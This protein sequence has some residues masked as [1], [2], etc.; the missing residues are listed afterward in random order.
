[1]LLSLNAGGQDLVFSQFYNSPLHLNPAL[2]GTNDFAQFN[3]NYRLQWPGLSTVY[4]SFTLGYNQYFRNI[5][6]GFGASVI[7]DSSGDGAIQFLNVAGNYMYKLVL[8]GDLQLRIGLEVGFGQNRLNYNQLIFGDQID[9]SGPINAG[10][11]LITSNEIPP[12][13]LNKGY[14]DIGTGFMVYNKN[15]FVG[16]T[17]KHLNTPDNG[18]LLTNNAGKIGLPLLINLHGSYQYVFD[19][20]NKQTNPSFVSP[21]VLLAKQGDF[22]QINVG[23]YVQL[24]NFVGGVYVRHTVSHFDALILSAGVN[25]NTIKI[26]YSY[27][28]TLSELAL[29]SGGSHEIGIIY[30]LSNG[31]QQ[32]S[33]LNDCL[34]LFR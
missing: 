15:W 16:L 1:M 32:Y 23:S 12:N 24:R 4:E 7:S 17:M 11:G 21:S 25:L 19:I 5:N 28:I 20:G 14:L 29:A 3:A 18:F 31:K 27:D 26:T 10:G 9:I 22:W 8:P 30:N 2:A 6:S 13:S 33:K 34:Q